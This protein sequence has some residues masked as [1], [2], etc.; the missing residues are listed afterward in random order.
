MVNKSR[1]GVAVTVLEL[2]AKPDADVL[3]AIEA[4]GQVYRVRL[5]EA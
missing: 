1:G 4:A 2:A 5:I 3:A